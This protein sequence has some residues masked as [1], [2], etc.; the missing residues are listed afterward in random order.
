LGS[1]PHHSFFLLEMSEKLPQIELSEE[2]VLE[3][4]D[5]MNSNK[6]LGPGR[7]HPGL[8]RRL[9]YKIAELP[10][11]MCNPCL[12]SVICQETEVVNRI[13][14]FK[15]RALG[16]HSLVCLPS[17]PSELSGGMMEKRPDK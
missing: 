13:L 9:S 8:P 10:T 14:T 7:V 11:A 5:E 15:E 4:V 12:P 1:F 16:N 2:E 17:I 3:Q 6:S